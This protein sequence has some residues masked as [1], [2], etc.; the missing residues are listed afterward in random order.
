MLR[1]EEQV[2]QGGIRQDK[3]V[4]HPEPRP[5]GEHRF[6]LSRLFDGAEGKIVSAVPIAADSDQDAV[7]QAQALTHDDA[8]ELWDRGRVMLRLPKHRQA[9]R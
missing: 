9:R 1:P 6:R 3:S 2:S 7:R 8:I 4:D 5:F